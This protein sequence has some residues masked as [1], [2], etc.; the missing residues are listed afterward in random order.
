MSFD[1]PE[2][3]MEL[4]L[5]CRHLA[6]EYGKRTSIAP[7]KVDHL[8]VEEA[9]DVFHSGHIHV[10]GWENY[11]GT[12]IVNSGAWQSQTDYQQRMGLIP[13]PGR[14]PVVNLQTLKLGVTDF[15]SGGV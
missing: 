1:H 11:R 5:K 9:P 3:A 13:T 7:L 15:A 6:P 2:K 8:V 10:N 4:E 14:L 12:L